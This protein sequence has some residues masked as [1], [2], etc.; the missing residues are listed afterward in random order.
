MSQL[1]NRFP[2]EIEQFWAGWHRCL[3]PECIGI[4]EKGYQYNHADCIH[5]IISPVSFLYV[6]G[7]FNESVF[8]SAPVNNWFCHLGKP[9]QNK[10]MQKVLLNEVYR[11]VIIKVRNKEYYL[12]EK[13]KKFLEVYKD[14]YVNQEK[15]QNQRRLF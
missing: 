13:D 2:P 1:Q 12:T 6:A 9:M 15:I 4:K 5:H 3:N 10:K 7:D 11:I 8:N 14:L